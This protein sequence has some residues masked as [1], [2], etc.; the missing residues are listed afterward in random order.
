MHFG[1]VR[2]SKYKKFLRNNKFCYGYM[3]K[4]AENMLLVSEYLLNV[5]NS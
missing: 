1:D 3:S 5:T 4:S 2:I